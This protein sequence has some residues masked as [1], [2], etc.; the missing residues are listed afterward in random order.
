MQNL[1][2]VMEYQNDQELNTIYKKILG[3]K[4]S[5][6]PGVL[7]PNSVG[8][9]SDTSLDGV[10]FF[11]GSSENDSNTNGFLI[12][13]A[14]C[15]QNDAKAEKTRGSSDLNAC[16][17]IAETYNSGYKHLDLF[18]PCW[19]DE[20]NSSDEDAKD[21]ELENNNDTRITAMDKEKTS[22]LNGNA[23][24]LPKIERPSSTKYNRHVSHHD[25]ILV[26]LN[27]LKEDVVRFRDDVTN[28]SIVKIPLKL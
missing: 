24:S 19:S 4:D 18:A 28:N 11:N 26:E 9:G 2:E 21:V 1:N 23:I 8:S 14:F 20:E 27:G 17:I 16:M 7:S 25:G 13:A 6:N 5:F 15:G 3:Y 12:E 10:R 22:N